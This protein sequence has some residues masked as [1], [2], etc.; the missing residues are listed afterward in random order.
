LPL[1]EADLKTVESY[2]KALKLDVSKLASGNVKFWIY[3]GVELP[4]ASAC[5]FR[6]MAISIPK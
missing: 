1:K 5:V 4:T 6:R 2:K 3:K